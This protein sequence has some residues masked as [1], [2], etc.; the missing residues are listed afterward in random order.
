MSL[1]Q[2]IEESRQEHITRWAFIADYSLPF[3]TGRQYWGAASR[4]IQKVATASED[5]VF[6]QLY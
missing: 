3:M 5:V 4:V 6:K 2:I 1:L